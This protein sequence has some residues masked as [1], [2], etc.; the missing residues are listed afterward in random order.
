MSDEQLSRADKIRIRQSVQQVW[1]WQ[2]LNP[3][4]PNLMEMGAALANILRSE[5]PDV[6]SVEMGRVCLTLAQF[7]DGVIE[8][9]ADCP[10]LMASSNQIRTAGF[11]LTATEWQ[12]MPS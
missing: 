1:D 12:E 8:S 11:D 9:G 2:R 4:A 3:E 10:A 6:D 5:L 7:I